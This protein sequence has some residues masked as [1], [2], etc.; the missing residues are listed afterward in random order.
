MERSRSEYLDVLKN[1]GFIRLSSEACGIGLRCHYDLTP[2]AVELITAYL[3]GLQP[4][5]PNM[6]SR[7]GQ[8]HSMML[9]YDMM[10]SLAIFCELYTGADAVV[11]THAHGWRNTYLLI[12]RDID[13]RSAEWFEEIDNIKNV[14]DGDWNLYTADGTARNGTSNMHVF[15]GRVP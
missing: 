15:T 5:Y 12:Y 11:S 10:R 1:H 3:G 13:L 2:E 8:T 7:E 9:P 6:N 4:Q 14:F